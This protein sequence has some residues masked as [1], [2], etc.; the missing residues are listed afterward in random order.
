MLTNKTRTHL[1]N[2]N[3]DERAVAQPRCR[4]NVRAEVD[5]PG[6]ID[7]IDQKAIICPHTPGRRRRGLRRGV[8]RN[9]LVRAGPSSMTGGWARLLRLGLVEERDGAGVHGNS[10]LLLVLAAGWEG[11]RP[12]SFEI[13][14]ALGWR[15]LGVGSLLCVLKSAANSNW[16]AYNGSQGDRRP[17]LQGSEDRH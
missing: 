12:Q 2:V 8:L 16:S 5:V 9:G 15:A 10:P 11:G 4:R 1:K 7:E 14:N 17:W 6:R 3:H 13:V